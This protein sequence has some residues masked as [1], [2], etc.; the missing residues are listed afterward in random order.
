MAEW[1]KGIAVEG[2]Q[3]SH[4]EDVVKTRSLWKLQTIGHLSNPLDHLERTCI[5]RT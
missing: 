4:M 2:L 3:E 5:E 1:M